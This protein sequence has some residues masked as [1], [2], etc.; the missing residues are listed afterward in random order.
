MTQ[1][2]PCLLVRHR[3]TG[4][5]CAASRYSPQPIFLVRIDH[6][7]RNRLVRSKTVV[8]PSTFPKKLLKG[9]DRVPL[10]QVRVEHDIGLNSAKIGL[11]GC[12]AGN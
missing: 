3:L 1:G 5:L 12:G 9:G 10:V 7:F 4:R 11:I 6:R 2:I 8:P